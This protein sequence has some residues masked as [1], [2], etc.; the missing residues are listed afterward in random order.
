M[1]SA[2]HSIVESL[3]ERTDEFQVTRLDVELAPGQ[4]VRILTGPFAD[5]VGTLDR[6][7]AN[8]RVRV[9][10]DIMGST[11]PVAVQ[12]SILAAAA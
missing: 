6:L 1:I 11:V 8:G 7:D 10:L 5:F 9:L 3:I 2:E 12:R 4:A